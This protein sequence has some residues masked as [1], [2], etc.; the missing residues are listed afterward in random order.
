MQHPQ[1]GA[2]RHVPGHSVI[3]AA[4][5]VEQVA[6]DPAGVAEQVPDP[7]LLGRAGSAQ[8]ELGQCVG[9]RVVQPHQAL[10]GKLEDQ[11]GRPQLGD[12]PDLEHRCRGDRHARLA[13]QHA[14]RRGSDFLAVEYRERGARDLVRGGDRGQPVLPVVAVSVHSGEP[15]G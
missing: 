15:P 12:G 14:R 2:G 5:V 8:A 6:V 3:A 4:G 7:D 9:Q 11:A 1:P 13:V 10:L